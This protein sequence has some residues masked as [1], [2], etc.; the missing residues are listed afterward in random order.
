[1]GEKG[2]EVFKKITLEDLE[3]DFRIRYSNSSIA[4]YTKGK[5]LSDIQNFMQYW[6]ALGN[7]PAR[8]AY[9][10]DQEAIIKKV[11]ELLDIDGAVLSP[12]EYK[13]VREEWS[14]A[15]V[16]ADTTAQVEAQKAQQEAAQEMQAEQQWWEM[17]PDQLA[18]EAQ[19]QA[20]LQATEPAAEQSYEIPPTVVTE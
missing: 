3:N 20:V 8:N 7:D 19:A 14:V 9:I 13:R 17:S 12:D 18:A 11:A 5:K 1:M 2:K 4:D 15:T 10:I 6:Q 16:Q